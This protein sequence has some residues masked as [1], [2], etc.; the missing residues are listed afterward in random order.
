MCE[1]Y[2]KYGRDDKCMQNISRKS[3]GK[4]PLGLPRRSAEDN[5]KIR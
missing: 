5:I 4:I 1:A 2:S 3:E